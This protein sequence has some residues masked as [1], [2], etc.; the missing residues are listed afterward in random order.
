MTMMTRAWPLLLGMGVLMLGAGLQGT[1]LGIRATAEAF[2]TMVTGIVMACYYVGYLLGTIVTP[3]LISS[4]GHV[5]VFAAFAAIAAAAN[6]TQAG[7]VSPAPWAAMRLVTG[8]CFAGIYVVAESWLNG[9]A[10]R[11]NR[12]RL[13]AAYMIVLYVG[14]GAAQFL[15]LLSNTATSAPFMLASGLICVAVV[16]TLLSAQIDPEVVVPRAVPL[17]DIYRLSP[18]GVAAVVVAGVISSI[19]FS[20]GPVYA[21]LAGQDTTDIATFMAVNIFAG[22]ATQ[23]PVGALADRFDR[24]TVI[25]GV[26]ALATAAAVALVLFPAMPRAGFLLLSAVF[27]GLTLTIYSLGISH[28]NDRLEPAQMVAASGV[29]LLLDGAGA[30]VGPVL[31]TGLMSGSGPSAYFATLA[32]L[33]G[34]LTLHCLW[35]KSRRAAVPATHKGPFIKT[36]PQPCAQVTE[37]P[38]LGPSLETPANRIQP[39]QAD[40]GSP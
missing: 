15:L 31:V 19:I 11:T 18:L 21:R 24:R 7:F 27:S 30:I 37:P 29:L 32:A 26:C 9:L 28:V 5:R 33:S 16:P 22:V 34:L 13:L 3:R 20:I 40:R 8:L 4:V 6:L 14:L 38:W 35:R 23:Y 25:A 39:Q 36:Q 12:S 1:L 17:R 2:P 10:S